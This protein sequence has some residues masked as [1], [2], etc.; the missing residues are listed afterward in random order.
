MACADEYVQRGREG[1]GTR[2]A[3]GGECVKCQGRRSRALV[4]SGTCM[5]AMRTL[6][7][8]HVA[9]FGTPRR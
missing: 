6:W 2:T 3:E 8:A 5:T 9:G 7:G 1:D 4:S